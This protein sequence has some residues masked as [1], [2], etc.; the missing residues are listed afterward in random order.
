MSKRKTLKDSQAAISSQA[1]EAG[2][3]PYVSPVG[4]T[5]GQSGRVLVPAKA[6]RSRASKKAM[7]THVTSG[8]ISSAS[9]ASVA[10]TC[11]LVSKLKTRF[12]MVGSME[13]MQTWREKVTPLGIVYWAHTA[14]ARRI[15]DNDYTGWPSPAVQNVDGGENPQGNTGEHFTLQTAAG[16]T[17]WPTPDAHPE[18]PNTGT[19]RENG[20]IA[21]RLT[22][23]GLGPVTQLACWTTPNVPSRGCEMDKSG[24]EKSGGIDLQSQVQLTSWVSPTAQDHTCGGL[25]ARPTD[26]GIP[27]SQQV[28][29][30]APWA[31]PAAKDYRYPNAKSYQER[32]G[33]TKGETLSNQ[34]A[35]GGAITLPT[36][37]TEKRGVLEPAFSRWLMGFPAAWDTCGPGWKAWELIQNILHRRCSLNSSQVLAAIASPACEDTATRLSLP[38]QRSLF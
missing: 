31:T 7:T 29:M 4:Q 1:L 8:P 18:A 30:M 27:L 16:L 14:S 6:T 22:Q 9:S 25:P 33:S 15:S 36:A 34:V 23:Q 19:R 24:R 3:S 37:A 5:S 12:A 32:G 2:P 20:R 35:H 38:S 13:Y 21:R 11:A 10:L 17:G 28:A 26:T